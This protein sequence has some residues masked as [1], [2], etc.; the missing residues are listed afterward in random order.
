MR[1]PATTLLSVAVAA[2][3]TLG[4]TAC[5]SSSGGAG[6]AVSPSTAAPTSAA[7]AP[8]TSAGPSGTG[9]TS[10]GATSTAPTSTA[11]TNDPATSASGSGAGLGKDPACMKVI[12]TLSQAQNL[13]GSATSAAD[14]QAKVDGFLAQIKGE[15]ASGTPALQ[16]AVAHFSTVV[17]GAVND[18][19]NHKTPDSTAV[20]SSA[21]AIATVCV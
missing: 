17:Q 11:P 5:G 10:T 14:A 15:A 1:Q 16:S 4:V 3:L 7:P 13:L 2:V 8:L 19:K 18:A 21:Q 20:S 6:G 12:T 9:A